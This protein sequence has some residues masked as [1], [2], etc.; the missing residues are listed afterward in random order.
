MQD[1]NNIKSEEI[2]QTGEFSESNQTMMQA[3]IS[4][5]QN[6]IKHEERKTSFVPCLVQANLANI[7]KVED[8]LAG[9]QIST[10]EFLSKVNL[11]SS[12]PQSKIVST[13]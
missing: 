4:N 1:F 7:V 13:E 6:G 9:E 11:K 10:Y 5:N 8:L 3:T 12:C 2:M